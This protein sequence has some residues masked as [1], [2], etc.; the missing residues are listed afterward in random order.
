MKKLLANTSALAGL[1]SL[2]GTV[3]ATEPRVVAVPPAAA[4]RDLCVTASGEV[5]H[6]GWREADGTRRRVY[7][8]STDW[9][10]TWRTVDAAANDV[11]PMVLSPYSGEWIYFR[12]RADKGLECVRSAVGPG[13]TAPEVVSTAWCDLELRQM[14]PLSSRRRW[15]ACFSDASCRDGRSYASVLLLSDDDGRTWRRVDVRPV[16]NVP[17][18]ALGDRRP[19]WYCD[20]GEPTAVELGDGT[21]LMAVRTSG[22]HVAFYR[23]MDG[24]ESWSEGVPN[25]AFW[26]ANTMPYLFRLR[27]GRLLFI[28]NNTEMLPTRAVEEYPELTADERSG[29]WES[30]FTNRD[31][32]HAAVSDDDGKT[33][34]GFREIAL[35]PNRNDVDFREQGNG[36]ADEHDKSVHQTQALER[37]DGTVL[38]ALG[39]NSSVRR[40]VVLDPSWLDELSRSE[41]FRQGLGAVS[42]HLYVRSLTG[43]ARGWAGHCAWNRVSGALLVREPDTGLST[44]REALQLCRVPDQRLVS[45]RQGVVWNFPALRRGVFETECRIEG[46]GF[47]LSLMDHWANPCDETVAGKAAVTFAVTADLIARATWQTVAVSWDLDVKRAVLRCG[48]KVLVEAVPSFCPASGFSYVHLQTLA[49]SADFRGTYFRSLSASAQECPK[50]GERAQ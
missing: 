26:Q 42:T 5:R 18:L 17:R 43:G 8:A 37:P 25:P 45:D 33:W 7:I 40:I 12:Q 24:G 19:H 28:W 50:E 27:N 39:Q 41:D 48:D 15:I 22:P 47:R 6:Y 1:L 21:L 29:R 3:S 16:P 34:R 30:V 23:S 9:G 14:L 32:L 44:V 20:G 11:G 13:D 35:S 38:L 10:E 2:A 46:E 4:V 49:E 31:A 36:L